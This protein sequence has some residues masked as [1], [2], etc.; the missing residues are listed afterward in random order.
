MKDS[1]RPSESWQHALPNAV[2]GFEAAVSGAG[3]K[4][5]GI[6]GEI[7]N[8]T[9]AEVLDL[10]VAT[11]RRYTYAEPMPGVIEVRPKIENRELAAILTLA[12]PEERIEAQDWPRNIIMHVAGFLPQLGQ[13]LRARELAWSRSTGR[14]LPASAGSILSLDAPIPEVSVAV[15]D[16]TVRGAL[17]AIAAYT[18]EH[19]SKTMPYN[20]WAPP[21]G[22]RVDFR[23][24]AEAST[25][26]GGYVSWALFP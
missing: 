7:K 16:T 14:P 4:A 17:D 11:D 1:M 3:A 9:V 25:G 23:P 10:M 12:V 6:T 5:P 26:L 8:G 20:P 15:R 13:Y 18:Q 24:D 19:G 2:I 22:W 21:T